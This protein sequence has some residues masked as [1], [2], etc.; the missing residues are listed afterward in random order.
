MTFAA[1]V[2]AR[3]NSRRLPNKNVMDLGG[4]SLIS[5]TLEFALAQH[6][7]SKIIV[8]TDDH[9]VINVCREFGIEVSKL[10]PESLSQDNTSTIDVCR[11]EIVSNSIQKRDFDGFFILQPTSPFR[12]VHTFKNVIQNFH[13]SERKSV[14]TIARKSINPSWLITKDE[15]KKY[16]DAIDCRED[17][18][19]KDYFIPNGNIYLAKFETLM[20]GNS[21]YDEGCVPV[22]P[23]RFYEDIDIDYLSDLEM[24]RSLLTSEGF[25]LT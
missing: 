5:W 19:S 6:E 20:R 25:I 10:R 3:K 7:I 17:T 2:T 12:S 8:S 21:L 16:L 4:K 1:I 24:A 18:E 15:G 11:Y 14:V 9:R 13:T 23:T 22:Q